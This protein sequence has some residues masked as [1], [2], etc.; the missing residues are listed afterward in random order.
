LSTNDY[1][2]RVVA[3]LKIENETE[4]VA[5]ANELGFEVTREKIRLTD[6]QGGFLWKAAVESIRSGD[7]FAFGFLTH[8]V[9][10][11]WQNKPTLEVSMTQDSGS[12]SRRFNIPGAEAKMLQEAGV[13]QQDESVSYWDRAHMYIGNRDIDRVGSLFLTDKRVIVVGELL[14]T[15]GQGG[16]SCRLYYDNW[17]QQPF[18]DAV[19]YVYMT[20][21]RLIGT[22]GDWRSH[23]IDLTVATKYY[24]DKR[25]NLSDPSFFRTGSASK[26]KAAEGP[27]KIVL[28]ARKLSGAEDPKVRHEA[29]L[30]RLKQHTSLK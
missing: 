18:L 9:S 12:L 22:E 15:A 16:T 13:F 17:N 3:A 21:V 19:D 14:S 30:R 2:E 27:V 8:I 28:E 1:Y 10:I 25:E 7:S 4:R 23:G 11:G 24:E 20:Q 6:E 26:L 5:K 29:L